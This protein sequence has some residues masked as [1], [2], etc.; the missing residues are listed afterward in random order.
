MK[1]AYLGAGAAGRICGACLHDNGLATAMRAQG[2]DLIL[3]PTYTPIRTDEEN[4]SHSR[5]FFGGI[6]VFLQQKSALFRHTP[7]FLDRMFDTPALLNW[8]SKRSSGM[9]AADLGELTVSTFQGTHGRQRKEIA[10]L[11]HWLHKDFQPEVVHL[12]NVMLAGMAAPIKERLK[13]PVVASLMGED[14]FLEAL[15][16]P[17]YSQAR[18]LLREKSRDVD[19]FVALNA[20]YADLMAEYLSVPREK[21]TVIRHGLNL[22]G[23]SDRVKPADPQLVTIGY[24]ARIAVEKGLHHLIEAFGLLARDAAL[25]PLKLRVAGYMSTADQ[26]YFDRIQERVRELNLA[27]RVEFVGEVD[28][29]GKLEFLRSLDLMAVP[30]VYHESKGISVLEALGHGIPVVLPAHGAFPEYLADTGGGAL[31]APE[32]P[33][34]LA[35][36]LR[37]LI[38]DPAARARHSES[39]AQAIRD[40]F[41]ADAMAREHRALYGGLVNRS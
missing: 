29:A 40:R 16:E 28:R 9:Q 33:A 17:H 8:L 5:V 4:V 22:A 26:P 13:V 37:G 36:A 1:I 11:L 3:I 25:P 20:Y 14:I 15:T 18:Q 10:K 7:W 23:Y 39:A 38:L 41:T 34:A 32:D 6:N 30:T 2:E 19:A 31:C 24:L 35:A 12:S 21:I 27:E